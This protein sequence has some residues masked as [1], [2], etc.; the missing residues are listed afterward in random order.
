MLLFSILS[1]EKVVGRSWKALQA[2]YH[3]G[4]EFMPGTAPMLIALIHY[5]FSFQLF[6]ANYPQMQWFIHMIFKLINVHMHL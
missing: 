2:P 1:K 3:P 5:H 4:K 6:L